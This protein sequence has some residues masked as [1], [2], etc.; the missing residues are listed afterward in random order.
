MVM[1]TGDKGY[2]A[3]RRFPITI[4][5]HYYSSPFFITIFAPE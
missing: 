1:S 4:F 2:G 5:H 3:T